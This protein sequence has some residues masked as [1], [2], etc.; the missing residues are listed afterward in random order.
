MLLPF[1]MNVI[2][3]LKSIQHSCF[4]QLHF[5]VTDFLISYVVETGN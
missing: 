1:E 4:G 5:H 3:F 2:I